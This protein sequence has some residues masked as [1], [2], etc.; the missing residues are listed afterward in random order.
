MMEG[1]SGAQTE[2]RILMID[3]TYPRR[4]ERIPPGQILFLV[5]QSSASFTAA[6]FGNGVP[7]RLSSGR[8]RDR[9][10]HGLRQSAATR[11]TDAYRS[12]AQSGSGRQTSKRS[13]EHKLW[14][15][16]ERKSFFLVNPIP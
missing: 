13:R 6:E 1:L 11:L 7:Q 16:T 10:A 3:A 9:L 8:D 14:W 4:T 15:R 5:T 12:E 2:R